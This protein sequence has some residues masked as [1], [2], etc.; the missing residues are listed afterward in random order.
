MCFIFSM[1]T[2]IAI[3]DIM[4]QHPL[5]NLCMSS[6]MNSIIIF[7]IFLNGHVFI[8]PH[9]KFISPRMLSTNKSIQFDSLKPL[10]MRITSSIFILEYAHMAHYYLCENNNCMDVIHKSIPTTTLYK[11]FLVLSC[12]FVFC[13][14]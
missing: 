4:H 9:W 5:T 7:S 6:L 8:V 2:I 1:H 12:N 10:I 11:C 13:S 14:K 3:K